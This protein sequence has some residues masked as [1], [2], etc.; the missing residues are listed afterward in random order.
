[1]KK[2]ALSCLAAFCLLSAAPGRA[3][4]S[5]T[6]TL[7]Q[8]GGN[9]V[10]DGSGTI[11]TNALTIFNGGTYKAFLGP[12]QAGLYGGPTTVTN[13]AL[14]YGASGTANFGSGG[15]T[16]ASVGSGSFVGVDQ[17]AYIIVPQGYVSGAS[18]SDTDTYTGATLASL[19]FTPGTYTYTWGT[20]SDADSLTVVGVAPE[21][22][23]WAMLGLGALGSG[24][25]TLRRRR[26]LIP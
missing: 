18:L 21:P 23:T 13:F 20:G 24:A 6:F 2:F 17:G 22:S 7:T 11:N 8:V 12:D 25:V 16:F 10:V 14:Y 19:G 9:V 4:A 1:M 26:A 15:T 3:H 5:F